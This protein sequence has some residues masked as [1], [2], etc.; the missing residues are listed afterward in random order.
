[1]TLVHLAAPFVSQSPCSFGVNKLHENCTSSPAFSLRH[2]IV[3]LQRKR[4]VKTVIQVTVRDVDGRATASERRGA[5]GQAERARHAVALTH[6]CGGGDRRR[7]RRERQRDQ[8]AHS[9]HL[10]SQQR[11]SCASNHLTFPA[12][13]LQF[14]CRRPELERSPAVA[15]RCCPEGGKTNNS[16]SRRGKELLNMDIFAAQKCTMSLKCDF[17]HAAVACHRQTHQISPPPSAN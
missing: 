3:C 2:C 11:S 13:I 8:E 4:G 9:I 12:N 7:G 15:V 10:K 6:E 14:G 1:M 17:V 16:N 5:V